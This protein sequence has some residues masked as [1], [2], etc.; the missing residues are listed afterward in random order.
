MRT[1]HVHLD[2]AIAFGRALVEHSE[3]LEAFLNPIEGKSLRLEPK[4]SVMLYKEIS[5]QVIVEHDV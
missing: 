2:G 1:T 3:N 4:K 5:G